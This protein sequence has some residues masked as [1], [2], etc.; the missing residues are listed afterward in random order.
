MTQHH[1]DAIVVVDPIA[2]A[3]TL[4][5]VIRRQGYKV[6]CLF[7]FSDEAIQGRLKPLVG[8]VDRLS[9]QE[10]FDWA[11]RESHIPTTVE[12]LR[13][14][15]FNIRAVISGSD[16]AVAVADHVA[17]ALGLPHNDTALVNARR[18]KSDMKEAARRAGLRC[19][20]FKRCRTEEDV[21]GFMSNR[22]FPVV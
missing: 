3:L 16:H 5:D 2:F 1:P 17:E 4:K 10:D 9:T 22:H 19:A 11:V 15:P 8:Y 13:G 12:R 20:D 14:A 21:L 7:T 18:D 6:I